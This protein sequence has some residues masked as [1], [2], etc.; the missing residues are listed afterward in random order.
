MSEYDR[1][2][3]LPAT[4]IDQFHREFAAFLAKRPELKGAGRA[5]QLSAWLADAD[6]GRVGRGA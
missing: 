3:N 4:D 1:R 6:K 2:S 5:E